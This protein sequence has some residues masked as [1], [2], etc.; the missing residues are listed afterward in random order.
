MRSG[1]A[2][3]SATSLIY[4]INWYRGSMDILASLQHQREIAIWTRHPKE[5]PRFYTIVEPLNWQVWAGTVVSIMSVC[6]VLIFIAKIASKRGYTMADMFNLCSI[7]YGIMINEALPDK[8]LYATNSIWSSRI[9]IW[10][11]LPTSY[12]I[13]MAYQSQLL[14]ALI[15]T[16]TEKSIN[17]FQDV[18]D[19]EIIFYVPTGTLTRHLFASS[20][21]PLIQQVNQEAILDRDGVYSLDD[22]GEVP[23]DIMDTILDGYGVYEN[24]LMRMHGQRHKVRRATGMDVGIFMCGYYHRLNFPL[25]DEIG[26]IIHKIVEHGIERHISDRYV[27]RF[28]YPDREFYRN[29]VIEHER[30][31]SLEHGAPVMVILS[32]CLGAASLAFMREYLFCQNDNGEEYQ[33]KKRTK[34][35][36]KKS[37]LQLSK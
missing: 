10:I 29:E 24:L 7:G 26:R 21:T 19:Q 4:N 27:W 31:L 37:I 12:L 34:S 32:I 18:L 25:M 20:P 17:T 16:S 3:V 5:V 14:A 33:I 1:E 11:W 15:K 28:T 13:S 9:V 6:A 36:T 2:D 8:V 30:K 22:K 23:K 35:Y